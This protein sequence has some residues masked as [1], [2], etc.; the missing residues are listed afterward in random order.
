[1]HALLLCP[2]DILELT[3]VL[4]GSRIRPMFIDIFAGKC[5]SQRVV[6]RRVNSRLASLHRNPQIGVPWRCRACHSP[7][8]EML[9]RCLCQS[10]TLHQWQRQ[11]VIQLSNKSACAVRLPWLE[12][13]WRG[14]PN[15]H[16]TGAAAR[17]LTPLLLVHGSLLCPAPRAH[18]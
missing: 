13:Q 10:A 8:K 4:D 9:G 16:S 5:H 14:S 12:V 7:D 3:A 1:M 2:M 11:T 6:L 17:R 15:L 18:R